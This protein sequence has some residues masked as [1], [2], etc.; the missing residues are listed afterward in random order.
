MGKVHNTLHQM[1]LE[2]IVQSMAKDEAS[3]DHLFGYRQ[4]RHMHIKAS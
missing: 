1:L 2:A 3:M 4:R